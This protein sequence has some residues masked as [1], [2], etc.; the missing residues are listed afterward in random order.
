[1]SRFYKKLLTRLGVAQPKIHLWRAIVFAIAAA[2][3]LFSAFFAVHPKVISVTADASVTDIQL[4]FE[5][6]VDT[7]NYDEFARAVD[8]GN[9]DEFAKDVGAGNYDELARNVDAGNHD[10]LAR[11]VDTGN[12]DA[13]ISDVDSPNQDMLIRAETGNYD[14]LAR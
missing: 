7:G 14:Q 11:S 6:N 9:Y 1:M 5:R 8:S 12:V 3:I 4:E 10:S 13:L 2:L